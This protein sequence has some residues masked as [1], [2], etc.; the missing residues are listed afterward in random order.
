MSRDARRS[1][2]S[3]VP[4]SF[5]GRDIGLLAEIIDAGRKEACRRNFR[6]FCEAYFHRRSISRGRRITSK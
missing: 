2:I 1:T 4:V 3:T 5:T 6:L